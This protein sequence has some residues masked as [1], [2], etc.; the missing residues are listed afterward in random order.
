[1]TGVLIAAVVVL[2]VAAVLVTVRMAI[3]PTMLDRAIAFDVVVAISIVAISVDAALRR[4]SE[5]LPLLLVAT[6]LGFVGSISI[7]RFSPGSDDPEPSGG[8]DGDRADDEEEDGAPV[9]DGSDG[10]AGAAG[11]AGE[12]TR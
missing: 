12:G 5:N 11:L 7:A 9:I 8:D 6:L 2:A 3:G 4:T 1:M 10:G